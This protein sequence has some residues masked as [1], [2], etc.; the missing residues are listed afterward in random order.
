MGPVL[1][2]RIPNFIKDSGN[3]DQ[4]KKKLKN[5]LICEWPL[6]GYP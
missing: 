5:I 6:L 3:R 4:F 2:N 1:L